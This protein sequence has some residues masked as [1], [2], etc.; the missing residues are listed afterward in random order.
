M[1][2]IPNT[3]QQQ[4]EMLTALGFSSTSELFRDIPESLRLTK[5]LAIPKGQAELGVLRAFS[6]LAAK[7]AVFNTVFRGG[8]AYRHYIPVIVGK[9]IGKE[10]LRTAYTPYQ[11]EVS[12]GVLQG[13]FE[14]QSMIC[15]LTGLD[16]ANASMY[17][18]ASSAAEAAA[19]CRD[20]KRKRTLVS[21]ALNPQITEVVRTYAWA[22]DNQLDVVP[23]DKGLTDLKCLDEM[24][25]DDVASLII[26][27]PNF[28]GNIE[29]ASAIVNIA[30]AKGV[31]VIMSVN[32]IAT[33]V[34]QTPAEC[35]ADIAVGEGQPLG[36]PL[37]FGGPYVG[38]MAVTKELMRKIPGRIVGETTDSK[39]QRAY[40]LT[41][42]A[43]EQHIRRETASS[44]VCSNQ[45]LCAVAAAV[46]MSAM[47]PSGMKDAAMQCY[48]KAHY[49]AA[50]LAKAGFKLA[51]DAPFFHEFVTE[52]PVEAGHLLI[53]LENHG[54][55][56]GLP[57]P[58][59]TILWCAT[60]MNTIDEMNKLV[61]LCKEASK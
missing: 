29:D 41:L 33:A 42:Q 34:L 46:Y 4:K 24:L 60:E 26:Q 32:P 61:S 55:L 36:I 9:I 50:E 20:R 17:D 8:G 57:L 18:G 6:D 54:I 22:S 58:D 49:L 43:R 23:T 59:G 30:H 16:V 14:F 5:E 21:D 11:P 40:V 35:G 47:G 19:L 44:N 51:Y 2:Y 53:H 38:F 31:K 13:I 48:S 27:Q 1:A 37:S 52:T 39:G 12:Q 10:R 25:T 3:K 56:G 7:N 15:R 28:Y 45:A